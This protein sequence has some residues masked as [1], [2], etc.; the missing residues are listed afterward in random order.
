MLMNI[1]YVMNIMNIHKSQA[2][3]HLQKKSC[4]P[5]QTAFFVGADNTWD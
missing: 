5:K 2:A 1:L 3:Y 4:A